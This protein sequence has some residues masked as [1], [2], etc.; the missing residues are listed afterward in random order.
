MKRFPQ[1]A[2]PAAGL[3][4]P[5]FAFATSFGPISVE[6]QARGT[7]YY[8]RARVATP[9]EPRMAPHVNQPYTYWRVQILEQPAGEIPASEI[10]VREPGGEIGD[11]G[12]HVAG[13]AN[14]SQGEDVF[15]AL[16]DTDEAGDVK[17][18]VGLASGKF[19][20]EA[21]K[22]GKQIVVSGLGLPVTGSGGAMLT[23]AEF[24]SLLRRIR[25]GEATEADKQVYV[26]LSLIHI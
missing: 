25:Q 9:G 17:E 12:Y 23:P 20:V 4:F 21:G 18:V 15:L 7:Q 5:F 1:I 6:D 22:D 24:S 14:F 8:V 19:R 26:N 2:G 13:T 10:E 16:K 11:R 3:F